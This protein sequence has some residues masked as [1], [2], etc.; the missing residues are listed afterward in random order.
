MKRLFLSSLLLL[1]WSCSA[2]YYSGLTVVES[3]VLRSEELALLSS[4]ISASSKFVATVD[5]YGHHVSG[6]LLLKQV[7]NGLYRVGFLNQTGIT[8]FAFDIGDD[9]FQLI[10][11]MEELNNK[12]LIE[13]V[14]KDIRLLLFR[15][16]SSERVTILAE[17]NLSQ[18]IYARGNGD[19]IEYY[20]VDTTR[21]R[22]INIE[23]ASGGAKTVSV[24]FRDFVSDVPNSIVIKH[25]DYP[26]EI[27]MTL[28][29]EEL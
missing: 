9:S 11:C 22:L 29:R 23:S 21:G 2:S 16:V 17:R 6:L 1:S 15:S 18:R 25:Y 28:L 27:Q 3:R 5:A 19:R 8:V 12:D 20:F 24:E 10:S 13:M 4:A 14:R 7:D 26:M